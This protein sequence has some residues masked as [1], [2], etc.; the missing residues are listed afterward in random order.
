MDHVRAGATG[1][2]AVL[3]HVGV[4]GVEFRCGGGGG[5]GCGGSAVGTV[6][7]FAGVH[8]GIMSG[9][10]SCFGDIW[11]QRPPMR[12]C[13]EMRLG[14]VDSAQQSTSQLDL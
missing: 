3:D 13:W 6:R 1:A 7:D 9:N 2:Q 12:T 8:A 11:E 10:R 4:C 5:K 14:L